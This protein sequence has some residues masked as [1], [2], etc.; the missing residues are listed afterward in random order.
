SVR[1]CEIGV[2]HLYAQQVFRNPGLTSGSQ[3]DWRGEAG[4]KAAL[5]EASCEQGI[6]APCRELSHAVNALRLRHCASDQCAPVG[7]VERVHPTVHEARLSRKQR[8]HEV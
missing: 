5:G 4:V 8:E 3:V 6:T 1:V 7:R 2:E